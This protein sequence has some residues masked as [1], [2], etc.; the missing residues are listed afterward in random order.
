MGNLFVSTFITKEY[1]H[2]Q[3]GM[4]GLYTVK[5]H[6][7]G[8]KV[9]NNEANEYRNAKLLFVTIHVGYKKN[10]LAVAFHCVL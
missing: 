7:V 9:Q 3:E 6:F 5:E 10:R 8:Y 2:F 1:T 4:F